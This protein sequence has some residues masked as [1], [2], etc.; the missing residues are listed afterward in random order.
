MS[1]TV[2]TKGDVSMVIRS[3]AMPARVVV[4][5][6]AM[7]IAYGPLKVILVTM[8]TLVQFIRGCVAIV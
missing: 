1:A 3:V 6:F 8:V 5:A 4:V 7:V 2:I